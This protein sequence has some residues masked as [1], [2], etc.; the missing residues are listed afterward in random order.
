MEISYDHT[1]DALY[2]ELT[3]HLVVKTRQVS[4]N[5]LLDVDEHGDVV[6]IEILNARQSGIDPLALQIR[7]ST[8]DHQ[9]VER[10]DPEA[11]RRGREAKRA[12][13]AR[14]EKTAHTE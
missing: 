5:F 11:I 6:G 3:D 14:M 13:L 10:P 9:T 2:I 12:A 7:H 4:D 1:V 8:A